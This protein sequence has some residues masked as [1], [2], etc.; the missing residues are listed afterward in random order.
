MK[1]QKQFSNADFY[2][3]CIQAIISFYDI[4][5]DLQGS[6]DSMPPPNNKITHQDLKNISDKLD[7]KTTK[8][9]KKLSQINDLNVPAILELDN[10]ICAYIPNPSGDGRFIIPNDPDKALSLTDLSQAY[11]GT[12]Y[13]FTLKNQNSHV[14]LSHMKTG[15]ALDWFWQPLI[16]FWDRYAE[17]LLATF[18]INLLA[19]AIPLY[20]LNI[21]DRV[22]VNFV[23]D[24]LIVLT[25]G[26][27]TALTFDFFFKMLR[28]HIIERI[29][30]KISSEYDVKLMERMLD[31]KDVDLHLSTGEKSNLF[32]ELQ[33]IKDFYA[34]RLVPTI[35]DLPFFLLFTLIIYMLAPPLALIPITA[36]VLILFI[37]LIA[38]TIIA[39]YT[40]QYFTAMQN[41]SAY[42]IE[43]LNGLSTIKALGATGS[44]LLQWQQI[45]ENSAKASCYNNMVNHVVS[46]LSS[47]ITQ[48][49]QVCI[50]FFG[51]YLIHD[52]SLTIGGLVACSIIY[53]RSIAP[54]VTM[55]GVLSRLKQSSDILKTIDTIFQLPHDNTQKG[56]KGPFKG[57]IQIRDLTYQYPDQSHPA[58]YKINLD[59]KAGEHIG[60]I[61]KTGAG[62]STLSNIIV[63]MITPNEGHAYLDSYTYTSIADTE[64]KRSIGY[65]PQDGHFFNGSLRENIIM[66]NN[67]IS[68]DNLD[69]AVHM[70]GLDLVMQQTAKG[71][72]MDVG[73]GGK[74]LS[75][76][77]RQALS[78][79][80]AFARDPQILVFDEPTT[81][82][83]SALEIRVKNSIKTFIKDKTFIMIT[84]RTSL[85]PLVSRL[86]LLDQG[87]IIAD[88]ARDDIIKKLSNR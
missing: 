13:I 45:T 81:G 65:V 40:M 28:T 75:G 12:C 17:I 69:N 25:M 47:L 29:A 82:M 59:I 24:T 23:E 33:G 68:K 58:L 66:G 80:R 3:E 71:L 55:A 15:H 36:A 48:I 79:A 19:L 67:N 30:V 60:L 26:V 41:K 31:I 20:T 51:A 76:G 74:C 9:K 42:L 21:Y 6:F 1:H 84:H 4:H 5:V 57:Q 64:L 22:V 50:V 10:Q 87:R 52:A 18:F 77:Q 32:R 43:M 88:G 70:S 8:V 37:N 73:E 56:A 62:K 16:S 61:G 53:G 78:L 72:D 49:A 2:Q 86:I 7:L 35:V 34:A 27:M 63:G 54:I 11:Q 14:D 46:N 44:K 39:K 85:L 83:D 38:Q